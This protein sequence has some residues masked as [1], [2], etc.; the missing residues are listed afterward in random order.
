L[1]VSNINQRIGSLGRAHDLLSSNNGKPASLQD[2][3]RF[4]IATYSELESRLILVGPVLPPKSS[5]A[6]V[7]HELVTNAR[8][9]GALSSRDGIVTVETSLDKVR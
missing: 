4:E 8:K 6:L 9:Y 1:F 3:I 7:V 2:L 5:I